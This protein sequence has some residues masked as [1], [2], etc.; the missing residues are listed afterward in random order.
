M[1]LPRRLGF[2]LI[3]LWLFLSAALLPPALA[4]DP[5]LANPDANAEVV[6]AT[7]EQ[8]GRAL[9]EAGQFADALRAWQQAA[10]LFQASGTQLQQAMALSNLSL[11][12]QQLGQW[13]AA[14]T[15]ITTAM[16]LLD[17]AD[18]A[19]V[20]PAV[21]A[22]ALDIQG[23]LQLLQGQAERAIATWQQAAATYQQV[24]D[25]EG[26]TRAQIN[27]AQA[28][29]VLGHYRQAQATLNEANQH[30]QSQ[31]DSLLKA[32]GLRSLGAVLR[33]TGELE[34]SAHVLQ[35][36]LAIARSLQ[37]PEAIA[38]TLLSLGNTAR[39]QG[40]ST[41]ALQLYQEAKLASS[42]I[43]LQI[44]AQLHQLRLLVAAQ[45]ESA[46]Q[47]LWP[48]IASQLADLPPGR[49]AVYAHIEL[50]QNL[51]TLSKLS[52]ENTLVQP[53]AELLATA[54]EQSRQLAD[55]RARSYGLGRLGSLYEST[56]QLAESA[57]LTEQ[58][59]LLAQR[60]EAADL[61]YQWYWQRGRLLRSQWKQQIAQQGEPS[62]SPDLYN[63]AVADYEQAIAALQSLRYDLVAVHPDVQFSFRDQVE[64]VYREFVDLLLQENSDQTA[65]QKARETIELLQVAELDNFFREACVA[66]NQALDAL[67]DQ[68]DRGAAVLYSVILP[69][70]VEVI[71]KMAQ[72]PL[73]HYATAIDQAQAEGLL[74]GLRVALTEPAQSL[75]AQALAQQ[76]Y[77]W[78]IEPA[79]RELAQSQI[80]T[81]VFVLDGPLQTVPM[82][83]LY[84]GQKYL[85]ETYSTVLAPGLQLVDP[86]PLGERS[87]P[88]LA[89][90]LT[91]ARHGFSPLTYVKSELAQIEAEVPGEVLL[92][93]QFTVEA[94]QREVRSRSFSIIHLATHGQFSSD[95]NQTFVLAWDRPIQVNELD[96]F[97][98]TREANRPDPVQLLI[99][100]ACETAAGDKRAVLG[101]A[102]VA[103]RAGARSTIASLWNINDESTAVLMNA[104]YQALADSPLTRA[105]ALRQAQL[106][107]LQNPKYQRPM[108]WA[109]YILL[110]SW[111]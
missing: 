66:P 82:A 21:L 4:Q 34:T 99:L 110:G 51:M 19:V 47:A 14:E 53:I 109:P 27:Q 28:L 72:Q 18:S 70:R 38:E 108:Y 30:L 89:A 11:T 60:L 101:I 15:A 96:N 73:Q 69:D 46:A 17:N 107:L 8:Q 83:A 74:A 55:P 37:A 5:F 80:E 71:L 90:G 103:Y 93:Q 24:A 76:V 97:L 54:V 67:V 79:A 64:P 7:F 63:R 29:R 48:Q 85:V 102:G 75:E 98:R 59:L 41:T 49:M 25:E 100:S 35:Q 33:S 43:S 58:A 111:L 88:T 86:Q 3:C 81:L 13:Q 26:I 39:T 20:N 87:L 16:R 12:Y 22:Q 104:F 95:P 94:L 42:D 78:L 56:G 10:D 77:G 44:S 57:A 52:D 105:D 32:L 6:E 9:Y 23:R 2:W 31:P 45:Q 92:D 84:D 40:D 61:S 36:S 106:A 91:E 62:R 65:L 1:K 50:A 68:S